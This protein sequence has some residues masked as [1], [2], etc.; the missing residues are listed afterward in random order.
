MTRPSD[1]CPQILYGRKIRET[2]VTQAPVFII[3]HPRT[4]TTHMHN[5]L[6]LDERFYAPNTFEVRALIGG[7]TASCSLVSLYQ[8]HRSLSPPTSAALPRPACGWRPSKG[9]WPASYQKNGPW[10]T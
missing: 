7:A 10:T 3:G 8:R 5:L 1:A 2:K 6:N 9:C 4:G